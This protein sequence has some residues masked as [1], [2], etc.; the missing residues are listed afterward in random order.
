VTGAGWEIGD[1]EVRAALALPAEDRYTL[2]LQLACDWE[3]A[4]GL[5]HADGWALARDPARGEAF[6]LWPHAEF[7]RACAH[8]P[9]EDAVAE[10]IPLAELLGD[11]LPLLS[12]EGLR[13]AAFPLPSAP[14]GESRLVS[15]EELRRDLEAELVLGE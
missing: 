7:A 10:A 14:E 8:G 6:P 13:V 3:E 2:L 12:E 5:R 15:P 9:W 11:L 1:D 4:W